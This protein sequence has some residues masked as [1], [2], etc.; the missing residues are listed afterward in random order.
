MRPPIF[1]GGE[2][3]RP[4]AGIWIQ[5]TKYTPPKM[6]H[7]E[8]ARENVV[9]HPDH[10]TQ[11]GIECIDAIKAATTG[12]DGYEGALTA[13]VIKYIWRWKIKN[14]AEDLKKARWYI[15]RLIAET[16]GQGE[17]D[18]LESRSRKAEIR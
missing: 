4:R 15:D 17:H 16:E 2:R 13:N 9:D 1:I 8:P 14:G 12:L 7:V 18:G 10:Y 5:A 11:G 6:P 3:M